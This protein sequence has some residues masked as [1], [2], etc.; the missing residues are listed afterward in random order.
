L[1]SKNEADV[2]FSMTVATSTI[3]AKTREIMPLRV[4][5]FREATRDLKPEERA[6]Y[7][8]LLMKAWELGG[9][10]PDCD[11]TLT[12]IANVTRQKWRHLRPV[13][14]RFFTL[15]GD[16]WV[17]RGLSGEFARRA[18]LG[19]KRAGAARHRRNQGFEAAPLDQ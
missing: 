11:R 15:Q 2:M 16:R 5:E 14:E 18:E 4:E 7:L 17:H 3:S 13:M 12:Y 19:A 9:S 8:E 6:V 1:L 10:L